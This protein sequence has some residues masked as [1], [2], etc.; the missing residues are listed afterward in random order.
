MS[1][2]IEVRLYHPGEEKDIVELLRIAFDTYRKL[3]NPLEYWKWKF[4]DTPMGSTIKVA[5]VD[6]KIIGARAGLSRNSSTRITLC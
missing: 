1:K 4:Q 5:I 6:N 3:K 2:E